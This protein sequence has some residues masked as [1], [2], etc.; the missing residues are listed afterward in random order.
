MAFVILYTSSQSLLQ[1]GRSGFGVVARHREIP[2]AVVDAAERNSQFS[3]S[4][5][6]PADRIIYSYRIVSA[7]G[8]AWHL[9]TRLCAAGAD[10]SGRTNHLAEHMVLD[11]AE[12]ARL[13][14]L[15]A[16]PAGV[17]LGYGWPGLQGRAGW[18]G[19][20]HA[21]TATAAPINRNGEVWSRVSP[22]HNP[23]RRLILTTNRATLRYPKSLRSQGG[24][25][26]I[27]Q[28]LAESAA[29]CVDFGWS[30]TFTTDPQPVDDLNDF[31]W[32]VA[33]EDSPI[34][35]KLGAD[36]TRRA[37]DF[38]TTPPAP[39]RQPWP[40][41]ST[42]KSQSSTIIRR[43]SPP[44]IIVGKQCD[45]EAP[46]HRRLPRGLAAGVIAASVII[47]I[48][49]VW[50][51]IPSEEPSPQF[52]PIP[53]IAQPIRKMPEPVTESP[54]PTPT[55]YIPPSEIYIVPAKG[56]KD[57][58]SNVVKAV[59]A[60]KYQEGV[61]A[62]NW[63]LVGQW[64][65][66]T[67]HTNI[68][69]TSPKRPDGKTF[70]KALEWKLD[71]LATAATQAP[72]IQIFSFPESNNTT[73][74]SFYII[75]FDPSHQPPKDASGRLPEAVQN[76][77]PT[78]LQVQRLEKSSL[79]NT[80]K[81]SSSIYEWSVGNSEQLPKAEGF[82]LVL[83]RTDYTGDLQLYVNKSDRGWSIKDE[84]GHFDE[85]RKIEKS[86]IQEAV[87]KADEATHIADGFAQEA[88][89]EPP[90]NAAVV[91]Y[92]VVTGSEFK[93]ESEPVPDSPSDKGAGAKQETK[94]ELKK[95]IVDQVMPKLKQEPYHKILETLRDE[96][97]A[98]PDRAIQRIS[99]ELEK[100]NKDLNA[101]AKDARKAYEEKCENPDWP[102]PAGSY[103]LG[104]TGGGSTNVIILK[105]NVKVE[106]Q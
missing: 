9:M 74:I 1:A 86:A 2:R 26:M 90:E 87:S 28:L 98:Q 5:G 91:L 19:S 44:T 61:S 82:Q 42:N 4:T 69:V 101:K 71:P 11:D 46:W 103:K 73:N 97:V 51:I 16:T 60:R 104:V 34:L 70:S 15:G 96:I 106:L 92:S 100:L 38:T 79:G 105:D 8:R 58:K 53:S 52:R 94:T 48:L 32:V 25:R 17:M 23:R 36:S 24:E 80:S 14:A 10:Y 63:P 37:L 57:S 95:P 35:A 62:E 55:P 64:T 3:R 67:M 18:L 84:S 56:P 66:A 81:S 6:F 22:D 39:P 68:D 59:E 93:P 40:P 47:V 83:L 43:A 54:K 88:A 12:A 65:S 78:R 89:K 99:V 30:A 29:E 102:S 49:Y 41:K 7:E 21:W 76:A 31:L 27:L 77:L 85:Q 33:P 50:M 20:S 13:R 72:P 75:E 45:T